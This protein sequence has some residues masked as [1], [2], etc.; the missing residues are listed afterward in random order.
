MAGVVTGLLAQW[1]PEIMGLSYDALSRIFQ[2]ELGLQT[3]SYM[4]RNLQRWQRM[5][6]WMQRRKSRKSRKIKLDR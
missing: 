5:K 3:L 6:L 4:P 2:N 1:T